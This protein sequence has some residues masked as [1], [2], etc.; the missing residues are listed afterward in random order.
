MKHLAQP[1]NNPYDAPYDSVELLFVAILV[2]VVAR[3]L[4]HL[5]NFTPI[6]AL[7]VWGGFRLKR[8]YNYAFVILAMLISDFFL[9]WHRTLLYVYGSLLATTALAS[10]L[11]S[12]SLAKSWPKLWPIVGTTLFGSIVFFLVTNFG[13]WQAGTMYAHT[14]TGL[15]QSYTAGIPFFR[16]TLEGDFFYTAV[17]FGLE[18]AVLT[19]IAKQRIVGKAH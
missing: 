2:G 16:G 6:G 18:W 7:A 19:A 1:H 9:G 5:P 10:W 17:F 14:I 15:M 13:V 11:Q 12:K 3:L 8:G 4:P